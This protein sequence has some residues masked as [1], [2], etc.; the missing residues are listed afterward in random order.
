MRTSGMTNWVLFFFS[1]A[2]ALVSIYYFINLTENEAGRFMA[3][4]LENTAS[5]SKMNKTTIGQ[6]Y[7]VAGK[8]AV[9]KTNYGEIE[10]ELF[11]DTAPNTVANFKKLA[12]SGFYNE[13]RFHR[14]IKGFMIQGGDPL[15]K[16]LAERT[17]WGTGG[18]GYR[19]NDELAGD[20]KYLEGTL[21]MANSGPN[22]NGSQFFIVTANPGVALPPSYTVF[23][24]VVKGMEV[25][26]IIE[27]AKTGPNDQPVQDVIIESATV[28]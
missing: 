14:V 15:S 2:A 27:S 22:T 5:A 21:A 26:L 8:I 1:I 18:P 23:G 10:L 17:R 4:T 3:T 16:D 19:F 9:L 28:K 11:A 25:A 6:S 13:V 7:K 12:E 20:E 24:K